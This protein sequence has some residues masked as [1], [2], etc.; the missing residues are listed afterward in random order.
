MSSKQTGRAK[1]EK[2]VVVYEGTI[3]TR[4]G[5]V[6]IRSGSDAGNPVDLFS[7]ND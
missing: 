4:A 3:S 5:T 1:Y 6:P 7:G 2:P